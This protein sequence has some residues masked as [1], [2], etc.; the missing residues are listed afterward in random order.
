MYPQYPPYSY[1][2]SAGVPSGAY[3]P[4][5]VYAP[6]Q[7]GFFP[8]QYP[9]QHTVPSAPAPAPTAR[10]LSIRDPSTG[11]TVP[12]VTAEQVEAAVQTYHLHSNVS[13]FSPVHGV[14]FCTHTQ[15][16][17]H[18][19]PPTAPETCHIALDTVCHDASE[20]TVSIHLLLL[21]LEHHMSMH[22][23]KLHSK[24]VSK[25]SDI[26]TPS[27]MVQPSDLVDLDLE[28]L[29]LQCRA[30]L[31]QNVAVQGSADF[32]A[33]LLLNAARKGYPFCQYYV[34]RCFEQ[35]TPVFPIVAIR[36]C[37]RLLSWVPQRCLILQECCVL[38]K[39]TR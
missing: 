12:V 31:P 13:F 33:D 22:Q 16:M 26:D 1:P 15:V 28:E 20:T 25:T 19:T 8:Q 11:L 2:F 38:A 29:F 39:H 18:I 23:C 7:Q 4:A 6:H 21:L 35:G 5:A 34:G 10:R 24:D 30:D 9:P 36:C 3:V 27:P 14:V 17:T 32:A 37:V